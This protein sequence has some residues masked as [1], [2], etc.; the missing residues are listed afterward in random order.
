MMS[1]SEKDE[2]FRWITTKDR[3][4]HI[5]LTPKFLPGIS[6]EE[7]ERLADEAGKIAL[8][9]NSGMSEENKEFQGESSVTEV[10]EKDNKGCNIAPKTE[11]KW[12]D[13]QEAKTDSE[14]EAAWRNLLEGD[15][16]K[17][18]KEDMDFLMDRDAKSQEGDG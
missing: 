2:F 11:E 8:K 1:E 6:R 10:K 13:L 14:R 3:E 7:A 18:S 15:C 12:Y 5:R 4:E 17:L 9:E 16:W